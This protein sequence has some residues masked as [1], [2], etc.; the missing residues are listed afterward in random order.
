VLDN[1]NK[2]PQIK[3]FVCTATMG[4]QINNDMNNAFQRLFKT[5]HHARVLCET[6]VAPDCSFYASTDM[7]SA[8]SFYFQSKINRCVN[9][10][11]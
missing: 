1:Q 7:H 5:I 4:G 8:N 3:K 10:T 9:N 6:M 11:V 2:F